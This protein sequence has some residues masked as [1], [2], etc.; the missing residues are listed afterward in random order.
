M[1]VQIKYGILK[2]DILNLLILK[3]IVN[4]GGEINMNGISD[5][6][7]E[8]LNNYNSVNI[9]N[10]AGN[11]TVK[12]VTRDIPTLINEQL[13]LD[14]NKFYIKGS[15]GNGQPAEVPWVSIF[16]RN[17]TKT[18]TKGIYL[19]FLIKADLTGMYLSLN[20][21]FT[22][23]KDK[24]GTKEGKVKIRNAA[25]EIRN[26]LNTIP[27]DNLFNINL[28]C[29]NILGKGY[30]AGNIAAK[31][32]NKDTIMDDIQ[33]I[34][35][36]RNYITAYEELNIIKGNRTVEEFYDY[37]LIKDDG[38][39]IN[40]YEELES[41]DNMLSNEYKIMEECEF[42]GKPKEKKEPVIDSKGRK[43]YPRD[44]QVAVNVLRI[45]G[46]KCEIDENHP[47]FIRK[48]NGENY[49]EPHHIIPINAYKDFEYSLDVEEN[50]CSVCSNCHNCLHYGSDLEK[51]VLLEKLY[52]DRKEYLDKVGLSISFDD[53]KKYYHL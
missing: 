28:N 14:I 12:V 39:E 26:I 13:K 38:Y 29:E 3:V 51:I 41:I 5:K 11:D 48:S 21:G 17:I 9:E 22:Y 36:I 6:F 52:K 1:R 33:I 8:V 19:V 53:L 16:I 37:L 44:T 34:D 10:F 4:I 31:Y 18:A 15:G 27:E 7:T 42:Y 23:F 47:S 20:Q 24:Y 35:D 2:I 40:D 46:Y 49:T 30:E 32:Y 43:S 25:R 45:A 50:I